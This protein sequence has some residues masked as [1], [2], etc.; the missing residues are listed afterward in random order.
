MGAV[1]SS[2]IPLVRGGRKNARKLLCL[3]VSAVA[4]L[5]ILAP[6]VTADVS[7]AEPDF[8]IYI[9]DVNGNAITTPLISNSMIPFNTETTPSGVR[10]VLETGVPIDSQPAYFVIRSSEDL[11]HH[12][13]RVSVKMEGLASWMDY[14]GIRV[15]SD[16]NSTADLRIGNSY[17][18]VFLENERV[19]TFEFNKMYGISFAT[20]SGSQSMTVPGSMG[21]IKITLTAEIIPGCHNIYLISDHETGEPKVIE[22]RALYEYEP[23]GPLP[24]LEYEGNTFEGWYDS[25]GKEVTENTL[26]SELPSDNITA[27]WE[28][29]HIEYWEE[30]RDNPDGSST[31]IQ[32]T[33]WTYRDG[34]TR[35]DIVE[36][37]TYPD[38][39]TK[40][41]ESSESKDP[42]GE[43]IEDYS[44]SVEI[45][46]HDDG[47]ET[48][49]TIEEYNNSDGTS[50]RYESV[51]EYD[52]E[53]KK[54]TEKTDAWLTDAEKET[55]EYEV[56][57]RLVD[58][59]E[60]RYRVETT[61]PEATAPDV[62]NAK[63]LINQ[64]NFSVAF[65]GME[66]VGMKVSED[67]VG[68]VADS[69]Y[70]MF[71][72][73]NGRYSSID[74]KV[75][76]MA[77]EMGGEIDYQITDATEE[78]MT[79]QQRSTIG[80]HHAVSVLLSAGGKD[81]TDLRDG[82]AE[83]SIDPSVAKGKLYL[84]NDDGTTI[85]LVPEEDPITGRVTY[86]T[87][88]L[89]IFMLVDD[90]DDGE[91]LFWIIIVA[92]ISMLV[93]IPTAAAIIYRRRKKR[94]LYDY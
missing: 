68:L 37:T 43:T 58:E 63:K 48:W 35:T 42:S 49:N 22:K 54:V 30:T 17:D 83:V 1:S 86:P 27:K 81:I 73:N 20:L 82:I 88:H 29:P 5:T 59:K 64:Y 18:A 55:R 84:V 61:I 69:G 56:N 16:D 89:S 51:A 11:E 33:R 40:R 38:G 45:K 74:N 19:K 14:Y 12:L 41:D 23:L 80:P 77:H 87:S 8:E 60:M 53:G 36:T 44:S 9:V 94:G 92:T 85:E 72:M 21:G 93:I 31:L 67:V 91:L 57:A 62:D 79:E 50:E 28:W 24:Q 76:K 25:N 34:S 52:K 4:L 3:A 2:G 90:E 13:F 10:Y 75:V 66:T 39:N 26:V 32:Y 6:M 7:S 15:C 65:V 71:V 47:S 78:E 70:G 46:R